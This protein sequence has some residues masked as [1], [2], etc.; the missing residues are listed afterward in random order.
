MLAPLC[1]GALKL[2]ND[3][4]VF[5]P[6]VF[7]DVH[8]ATRTRK[9]VH[10]LSRSRTTNGVGERF[11]RTLKEQIIHGRTYRNRAELAAAVATFV[12]T[13]N[14]DWRLEKLRYKS[15]LDARRDYQ[16]SNQLAA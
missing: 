12:E 15:P 7:D 2:Q 13:Y 6:P 16:P 8:A 10:Q 3:E 14:R 5:K 11:N 1:P 9:P 4:V